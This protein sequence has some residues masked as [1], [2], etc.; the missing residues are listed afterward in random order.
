VDLELLHV[1]PFPIEPLPGV[2]SR[3]LTGQGRG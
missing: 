3:T 2:L 1:S